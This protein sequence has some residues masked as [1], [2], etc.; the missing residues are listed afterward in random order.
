M[1]INRKKELIYYVNQEPVIISTGN[2]T[3]LRIAQGNHNVI[4]YLLLWITMHLIDA[5]INWF[6]HWKKHCT[7]CG[8]RTFLDT[9]DTAANMTSK[10]YAS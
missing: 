6:I 4:N 10:V 7:K 2:P 5:I 1:V 3:Y 9:K 8:P